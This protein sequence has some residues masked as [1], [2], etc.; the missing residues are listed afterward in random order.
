MLSRPGPIILPASTPGY[1]CSD[2]AV[3]HFTNV[4]KKNLE[5]VDLGPLLFLGDL[6]YCRRL[7]ICTAFAASL[8]YEAQAF[9]RFR[10]SSAHVNGN[11]PHRGASSALSKNPSITR[12]LTALGDD[13]D[14]DNPPYPAHLPALLRLPHPRAIWMCAWPAMA[15]GVLRTLYGVTVMCR[16]LREL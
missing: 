11:S 14:K 12:P 9:A 4:Q 10:H 5:V 15:I 2:L 3:V 13:V 8:N 6:M 7:I 1:C 16:S